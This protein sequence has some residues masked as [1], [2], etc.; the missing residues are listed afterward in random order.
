MRKECFPFEIGDFHCLAVRDGTFTY[1]PPMFPPP[2]SFL[3]ANAPKERL[4]HV[5]GEH[6]L[7]SERWPSWTSPYICVVINTGTHMVLV[8]TG[9]GKLSPNT[10]NLLKHLDAEGIPPQA[11]DTVILT[12][13][14]PDHIG[15]N[16]DDEGKPAFPNARYVMGK[17]EWE[18]WTT[19]PT[20]L[21]A[22]DHVQETLRTI[23]QRNLPPIRSQL[24]LVNY[25]AEIVP[26]IS[27]TAAPGHTLGHMAVTVSSGGDRLFCIADA[28]LHPIHVEEP[29][30]YAAID[31]SP[32]LVE[33]TR[34]T[35]FT[36]AVDENA[37]VLAFH[38]PFPGLGHIVEKRGRWGWQ[39]I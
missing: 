14:H 16:V 12:H 35:L 1:A 9:A 39:P 29:A 34:R 20:E 26:G 31:F 32:R 30:W 27:A 11:I 15:G 6:G 3:F 38:F 13:G 36:R 33:Q 5:L 7:H 23:A 8:D 24:R 4:E 28:A 18:F 37:W 22:D 25:D 10:G 21:N 17:E 19:E 2:A